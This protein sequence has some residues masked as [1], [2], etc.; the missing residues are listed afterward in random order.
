MEIIVDL[1]LLET[2][3]DA[4]SDAL[5]LDLVAY[6]NHCCRMTNICLALQA[7]SVSASEKTQIAAAFHDIGIWTHR[8]F[9]YLEPSAM[10]AREYLNQS[11]R[12]DWAD[13]VSAMIT[14]HHKVTHYQGS[15][16]VEAFRRADLA[17]VSLGMLRFGL[18][19]D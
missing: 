9:D 16:L 15:S 8:T 14:E 12:A 11:G 18:P 6:R 19:S 5:G 13:E 1:P 4:H 2:L 17:D 7:G 3:L 10:L